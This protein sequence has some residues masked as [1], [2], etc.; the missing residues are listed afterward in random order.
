M[1]LYVIIKM[2]IPTNQSCQQRGYVYPKGI[3]MT[4]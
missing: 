4:Y 1:N 2:Q 3:K